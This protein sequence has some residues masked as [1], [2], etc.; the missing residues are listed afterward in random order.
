MRRN[1]PSTMALICFE[2][3]ANQESFTQ[4]ANDINITQSALSRQINLLEEILGQKLF[5]RN[6]Q[7]VK[8]STAG[9]YYLSQIKPLLESLEVATLRMS[10]FEEIS[11]ALNIGTYPTLG[12]RWLMPH[13]LAFSLEHP[14]IN[15]NIVTYIDNQQ[16][17]P[18]AIDI[19]IM[20]GDPPWFGRQHDFLCT[21]EL[22]PIASPKYLENPV[23]SPDE[24]LSHRLLRHTT[25]PQSWDIWFKSAGIDIEDVQ[26]SLVFPQFEMII[27]ATLAGH[28]IAMLP[29]ILVER[30]LADGRLMLAHPHISRPISGYYLV[31]PNNKAKTPKVDAFRK[32]MLLH[33]NKERGQL[34]NL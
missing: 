29:L 32:W 14:D 5:I 26:S 31:A 22:A 19:G 18:D 7:R 1:I 10:A 34:K 3:A 27:E 11:G 21:E 24:L 4:A 8:L 6:R 16:F 2:A 12:A 30:E 9:Q 17:S 15:T 23:H 25:R 28:G 13:L 33:T 20:Q